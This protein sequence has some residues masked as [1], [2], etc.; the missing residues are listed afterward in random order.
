MPTESGETG[1]LRTAVADLQKYLGE[2]NYPVSKQQ[3]LEY[4]K[5][6]NAP[7]TVLK[8]ISRLPDIKYFYPTDIQHEASRV[9]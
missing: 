7:E 5:S 8:L 9:T 1:E 2:I 3:L 6:Q 4:A